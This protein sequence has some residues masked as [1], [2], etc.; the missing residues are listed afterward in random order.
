M[1]TMKDSRIEPTLTS[2]RWTP[3]FWIGCFTLLLGLPLLYYGYCWGLWGR[4]SLLLQYLFQCGCPVISNEARYPEQVDVLVPAC[5]YLSSRLS[6]SGRFLYVREKRF[7]RTSAY[8]LDLQ[9]M[10]RI[11]ATDQPFSSFLTDN[12]WF[13]EN[14][15][16]DYIIDR[17]TGRQY[18]IQ[19]FRHW[20]ENAYVNGNPNLELLISALHKAEQVF[21]TPNYSTVVVLMPNFFANPEQ[22]FSFDRSDFPEW[23]HR[24]V[25]QFLQENNVVYQTILEDFPGEVA[26]PDGRLLARS[27]GVYLIETNQK[28]TDE[29]FV[30]VRGWINDSRAA[31]Y[32]RHLVGPCLMRTNFGILDDSV[33]FFEVPQPVLRLKVPEEYLLPA[34]AP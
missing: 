24:R 26:S 34:P 32:S 30:S 33:C 28:I 11:G 6:P 14:G 13:D 18:P 10:E 21:L 8:L 4:S 3:R 27:D 16:K 31:V 1:N 17:T 25:E 9:T 7:W 15:L 23:G 5:R 22:S 19:A 29:Y 12:L 20:Q 2:K